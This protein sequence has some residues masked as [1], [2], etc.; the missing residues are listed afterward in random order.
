MAKNESSLIKNNRLGPLIRSKRTIKKSSGDK[1]THN[2]RFLRPK[3][4]KRKSAK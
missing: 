1:F 2:I 3:T 4:K